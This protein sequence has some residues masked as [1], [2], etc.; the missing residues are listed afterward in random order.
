VKLE[1]AEQPD[2]LRKFQFNL[3]TMIVVTSL[4]AIVIAGLAGFGLVTIV[5]VIT[6]S[7]FFSA[8]FVMHDLSKRWKLTALLGCMYFPYAWVL[9]PGTIRKF[10]SEHILPALGLPM[11]VPS[12]LL[13]RLF[14]YRGE[15]QIFPLLA[16]TLI[17]FAIGVWLIRLG[18]RRAVA[19]IIA[20]LFVSFLG[21]CFLDV[22][23]RI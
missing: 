1:Q 9:L 19:W 11:F 20:V 15:D 6:L 3:R 21:S 2:E 16:L 5:W 7:I 23:M 10:G 17:E 14:D 12:I 8:W 18:T 22:G 4:I 13:G